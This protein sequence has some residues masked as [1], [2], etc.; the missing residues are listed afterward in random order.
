MYAQNSFPP[1]GAASLGP[2]SNA[3]RLNIATDPGFEFY[4]QGSNDA[5]ILSQSP[6]QFLTNASTIH[7]GTNGIASQFVMTNNKLGVATSTPTE[8]LDVNGNARIRG[9]LKV[10][11]FLNF[12]GG[13][14]SLGAGSGNGNGNS[15]GV[16]IGREA[17]VRN[18]GHSNTFVGWG[19]GAWNTTGFNNVFLGI[20]SG[21]ILSSGGQNT[22]IGSYAGNTN[23][24]FNTCVG[25]AAGARPGYENNFSSSIFI[26][27]LSGPINGNTYTNVVAIG[28]DAVAGNSN[29]FVLGNSLH[30][31][32]IRQNSPI[33]PLHV[34]N[35]YC[36]GNT[37]F[38]A[39]DKN[40]KENF[41]R[42]Q[43]EESVL[44][45]V[46]A[47]P[48]QYWNYKGT[49][50]ARHIGPTAQD[51]HKTFQLG[52]NEH[53]IASVD[54]AGVALA[55]IQELAKKTEKLEQLLLAQQQ[56]IAS[57]LTSRVEDN[58]TPEKHREGLELQ[59]NNPNP[60]SQETE[61]R[62]NIPQGI[63]EATLYVYDLQGTLMKSQLVTQRGATSVK[64]QAGSLNAG[65]YL[66]TLVA[67][68]QVTSI[69]RMIL[70]E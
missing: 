38:N 20:G 35:A 47:L 61:I 11:N 54:E 49:A 45:K 55:A 51:F 58:G 5:N 46:T 60:F 28:N 25:Q 19:S 56:L 6:L 30:N 26:G 24:S 48:I 53:A 37:W 50:K 12:Y 41:A 52:D 7:F 59:Q 16:F 34:Q 27:R 17:G 36:D 39:S 22:M 64:F 43:T 63:I 18:I 66:Y 68:G 3:S 70:T 65:M 32:G 57:L 8:P 29:A 62:M 10:D 14:V 40:L 15:G 21:G 67:D 33:Y 69:K 42:I 13:V 23:G 1:N 31:I 2:G 4:F 44:A 9:E